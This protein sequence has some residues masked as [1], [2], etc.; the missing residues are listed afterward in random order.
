[1]ADDGDE[2]DEDGED[3]DGLPDGAVV[4]E[5]PPPPRKIEPAS[6][7]NM[8]TLHRPDPV[9]AVTPPVELRRQPPPPPAM[10]CSACG[11]SCSS[12]EAFQLHVMEKHRQPSPRPRTPVKSPPP[13]P[14]PL[15]PTESPAKLALPS[16]TEVSRYETLIVK[17]FD[18][19]ISY[20]NKWTF[21]F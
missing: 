4:D 1:M 14:P 18:W 15:P 10:Y 21:Y 2:L 7:E 6:Q 16:T 17:A 11:E 5:G 9:R 8:T 13:P 3:S 19:L 12:M 20:S